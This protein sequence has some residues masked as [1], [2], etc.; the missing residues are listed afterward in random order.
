MSTP[1]NARSGVCALLLALA[2]ANSA[3]AY[4]R[5]WSLSGHAGAAFAFDPSLVGFSGAATLGYGINDTLEL[6]VR[7]NARNVRA[8]EGELSAEC[9]Y[10]L[11][12][13][14][15]VPY[16]GLGIGG[17]STLERVAT[18]YGHAYA[19]VASTGFRMEP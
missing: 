14:E 11:D 15:I 6:R 5:M 18:P 1:S 3:Q 13:L 9:V 7:A 4:D 2:V 12:I 10:L 17:G 19:V 16:F 8:W